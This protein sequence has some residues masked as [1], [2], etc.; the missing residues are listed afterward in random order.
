MSLNV[1][2]TPELE[3][4]VASKVDGGTYK[5]ASEV[6]RDGLRL[7][8]AADESKAEWAAGARARIE[9]GWQEAQNG[10]LVDGPAAMER[11]KSRM[12]ATLKGR[13]KKRA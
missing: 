4:Y 10:Q 13:S 5:S 9:H 7:L 1:S 8:Q 6:V 2:L 11:I 3:E 12:E